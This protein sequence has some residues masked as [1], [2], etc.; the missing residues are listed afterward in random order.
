M[1]PM[2]PMHFRY[3]L[4]IS[5]SYTPFINRDDRTVGNDSMPQRLTRTTCAPAALAFH[6]ERRCDPRTPD[7]TSH[8]QELHVNL[9]LAERFWPHVQRGAPTECW[10]WLRYRG[11]KGYGVLHVDRKKRR[12]HRVAYFLTH[13]AWPLVA[14][15]TC[16]N[17]PCCNP[18][19]LLD[20]TIADN[21]RD[22]AARGRT[23]D[24]RG[25][26]HPRAR[27]SVA[28]V[29]QIRSANASARD[30]AT[31]FGVSTNHIWRIRSGAAWKRAQ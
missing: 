27:L 24:R 25:E 11:R 14:R 30:L 5:I 26:R 10:P 21:Q 1:C 20:G 29:V 19:H 12:A 23:A 2:C 13:G 9:T 3:S 7:G 17:P 15:H 8:L 22:M 4:P 6:T 18:A 16:D 31:Q 28:D